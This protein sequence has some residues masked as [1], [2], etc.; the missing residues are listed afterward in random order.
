VFKWT[1]NCANKAVQHKVKH[2]DRNGDAGPPINIENNIDKE[3]DYKFN[4]NWSFVQIKLGP[5]EEEVD[6]NAKSIGLSI[7]PTL[8]A[9]NSPNMWIGDTG[10]T[11]H[12]TKHKQG[13]INSQ[14]FTIRIVLTLI[15]FGK[16]DSTC[17]RCQRSILAWR[18]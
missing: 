7:R 13:G 8:Q 11:K 4:N 6:D 18:A 9:M 16:H 14:L 17:Y 12:S 3:V 1:A 15:V 5:E 2:D 10:T